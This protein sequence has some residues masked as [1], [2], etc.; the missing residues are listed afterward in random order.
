MV[1]TIE[2][3]RY[4]MGFILGGE[5]SYQDAW[6]ELEAWLDKYEAQQKMHLTL[7]ESAA[8]DSESIPAPKQVI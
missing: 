2:K 8:S 4:M 7:G 1:I 3:L 5:V 6:I